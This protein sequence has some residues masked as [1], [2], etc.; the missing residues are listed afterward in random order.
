VTFSGAVLTGGRSSRLGVDKSLLFADRV[1]AALRAAGATEVLR[2]GGAGGLADEVAGAGPLGGIATALRRA[3]Q[4]VVV[5]LACDLPNVHADGVRAVVAGLGPGADVAMPAGQPLH[6][7]WHRRSLPEVLAALERGTLAVRA[8]LDRLRVVEV[9]G[10]DPAWLVNVNR[11]EDLVHTGDV[12]TDD[13]PEIDV[14]ALAARH[15]AGAPVLDVRREDEY[16][17]GH[18]PGAVLIPLDQLGARMAE[19][20]EGEVLVICRSGARSAAAVRALNEAGRTTCNVAGGTL[21]WIEAG[22][23]VVTG[24]EP[25]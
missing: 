8:A 11:P 12:A 3:S 5:V 14:T 1:E 6:A 4:D 22:H 13:I 18:V 21:A 16:A 25:R 24:P 7:A 17:E 19:V 20:P 15:A 10:I 23:P 9:D 2:V